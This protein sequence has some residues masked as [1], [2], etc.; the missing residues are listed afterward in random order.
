MSTISTS[1]RISLP[2]TNESAR[3]RCVQSLV[4]RWELHSSPSPNWSRPWTYL[5]NSDRITSGHSLH[6]PYSRYS[7]EETRLV[8]H[9]SNDRFFEGLRTIRNTKLSATHHTQSV[10]VHTTGPCRYRRTACRWSAVCRRSRVTSSWRRTAAK[11][12]W[13]RCTRPTRPTKVRS[14]K[15]RS[16]WRCTRVCTVGRE[17]RRARGERRY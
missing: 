12:R 10:R 1:C 5:R 13:R 3:S 7:I 6:R 15:G 2:I 14:G 8:T 4:S 16:T 17:R 9:K 11:M